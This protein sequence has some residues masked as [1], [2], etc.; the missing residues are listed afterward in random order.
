MIHQHLQENVTHKFDWKG[1]DVFNIE[2][3]QTSRNITEMLYIQS[4]P[5]SINKQD[6]TLLLNDIYTNTLYNY[7]NIKSQ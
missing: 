1:F 5:N 7:R 2:R 3:N 6:D 4:Q